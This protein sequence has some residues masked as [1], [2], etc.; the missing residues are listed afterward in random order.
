[1]NKNSNCIIDEEKQTK[2]IEIL[3]GCPIH[4]YLGNATFLFRK[5]KEIEGIISRVSHV[6]EE[7]KKDSM[8]LMPERK[9]SVESQSEDDAEMSVKI[10]GGY[11]MVDIRPEFA[12]DEGKRHRVLSNTRL[13]TQINLNKLFLT[14]APTAKMVNID[15]SANLEVFFLH[16]QD[17]DIE[18]NPIHIPSESLKELGFRSIAKLG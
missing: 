8:D 5:K 15:A 16:Y 9:D 1:V 12:Y 10:K 13:I 6:L 14:L 7:I 3:L 4:L 18:T 2:S 17:R 11:L